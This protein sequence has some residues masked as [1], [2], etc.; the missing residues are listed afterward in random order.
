MSGFVT[1]IPGVDFKS[2]FLRAIF[3]VE[4]HI[5]PFCAAG[6]RNYGGNTHKHRKIYQSLF[7]RIT[8]GTVSSAVPDISTPSDTSAKTAE[9]Q[10][11][12]SDLN[13]SS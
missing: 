5:L 9:A 2:K 3:A 4:A 13:G 6:K 10:N 1:V 11:A 7:K 8:P 12:N